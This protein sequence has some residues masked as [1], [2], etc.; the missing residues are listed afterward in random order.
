MRVV[1]EDRNTA[2]VRN[3]LEPSGHAPELI[4]PPSDHFR[5][6]SERPSNR[7]GAQNIL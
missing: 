5:L 6:D 4:D 3:L 7:D 1:D 2:I